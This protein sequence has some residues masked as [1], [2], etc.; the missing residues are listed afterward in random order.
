MNR[1]AKNISAWRRILLRLILK[2]AI[3]DYRTWRM[4]WKWP[5]ECPIK[6]DLGASPN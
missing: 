4:A 2:K 1:R 6:V 5:P 3:L